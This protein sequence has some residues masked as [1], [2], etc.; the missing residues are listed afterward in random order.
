[1]IQTHVDLMVLYFQSKHTSWMPERN[2]V[3]NLMNMLFPPNLIYPKFNS[4]LW[5]LEQSEFK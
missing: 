5:Y 3:K 1:M 2:L 4:S